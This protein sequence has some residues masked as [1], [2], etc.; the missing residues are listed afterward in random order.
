MKEEQTP[1]TFEAGSRMRPAM[2]PP[3]QAPPNGD[4]ARAAPTCRDGRDAVLTAPRP[5]TDPN[6]CTRQLPAAIP[7]A[8]SDAGAVSPAPSGFAR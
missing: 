7:P 8:R 4:G 2:T 5:P 1:C 3:H 6:P